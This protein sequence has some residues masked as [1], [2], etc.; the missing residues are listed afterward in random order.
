M[1]EKDFDLFEIL[2]EKSAKV[3]DVRTTAEFSSG[4]VKDSIN[5]PVDQVV[6]SVDEFKSMSKPIVLCCAS[7]ARSAMAAEYLTNIGIGEV[8]NGGSWK[9]VEMQLIGK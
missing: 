1:S 3:I 6:N 9:D 4:N 8:Y 5:I 2:N 7:G